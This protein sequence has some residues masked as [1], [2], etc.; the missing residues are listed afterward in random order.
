MG[1]LKG[2]LGYVVQDL[3][4][5]SLI[6]GAIE[7]RMLDFITDLDHYGDKAENNGNFD[8]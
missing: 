3:V 1:G 7:N 4:F 8:S 2:L 6:I 5:I